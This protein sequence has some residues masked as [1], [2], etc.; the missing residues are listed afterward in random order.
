MASFVDRVVLHVSG[1]TGGHGC[2][3]VKRE[4]FKPLGGPDGGNGGD[5]GDV[6]LRVSSQTTTLLDYHHAPHRHAG[7]GGPGMGDW[8]NGKVGETLILPVPDGTVVKTKS[9]E[10]LA[11]LV[12]EGSE[13]IAAAGGQGGLGNSTLS[14]QKRKA[15]GFALLG[16]PGDARDVV[17]ELK[18][19]ADIALVGFPSAGK[20]SLIAAM[21]A[22]RPK[23]ADYPFTTLVPNLGVVEAGD[24]R[25]TIADVPGLIEGASE[26][27]G[28]GH[29]FLRHV[30]RC[31]ALVHV[32]DCAT[33]EA[34]RD[35]LG[36]LAVIE[37]ELDRY[38]VDMSYAGVD[39]DVVPLNARPRL[40]ALNK[41]DTPDGRDMA[42]FVRT[43]L[44]SRGY[45]V[46]AV[47][48][49]SHEGLRQLGFAMAEIVR[50][51][52]AELRAAPPKVAPP[53]LR[54]RAVNEAGF[55]IR[56]EEKNLEPLFRVLGDKPEKWVMQTDF[57][58]EEAIG[59]LGD[60][61]NKLGVE[62][63]LF[64]VGAK[65]GDTVV[66][67]EDDGMVFD[68]E[69]TMMGG[70]ENLAG[71]R[72]TDLRI[73]DLGERPTRVQKREEQQDRRAAKAAARDELEAER[74][75]GIWTESTN[76][77][78]KPK[79]Q[80]LAEELAAAELGADDES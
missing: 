36:D 9:G 33:L 61:L 26:G 8:R 20:S 16:I 42:E 1:G 34:D 73:A 50:E 80:A 64:K 15:P 70:A 49:A 35:P 3:S 40:V 32:L 12:G 27:K 62:A 57:T 11:D 23:I 79:A 68:W 55:T 38:A 54:P 24:V 59:Y 63:K 21:S 53:V 22:A 52:R 67:G 66:I 56:R 65:P 28:L 17:L 43:D 77:K 6:I 37:A 13:Y 74:K 60:R 7:N 75:A 39:G 5:G 76:R 46:F 29:N 10:V 44:E 18:S 30:E 47:S 48:A 71:P 51:A 41:V 2:V 14:S 45:K 69:P 4:K 78:N 25:F 72:G 58:N 19:I 31:A